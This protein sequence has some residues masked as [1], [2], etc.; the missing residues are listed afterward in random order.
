MPDIAEWEVWSTTARVVVTDPSA[1]QAA[2]AVV[3]QVLAEVDLAA[4]R[5]RPDSEIVRLPLAEGRPQPVGPLLA[6]LVA[7]AL[8]AA[9]DTDGDVDPTLAD[10]LAANGYD[11]DIDL[12]DRVP[13]PAASP[14]TTGVPASAGAGSV[15][16]TVGAQRRPVLG[17]VRR[18]RPDWRRIRLDGGTLTLP[19]GVGLDLGATAKAFAADRAARLVA[20]SCGTGV[21]VGLGGDI[22]TAGPGPE[23]GWRIRVQDGDDEPGCTVALPAGSALATSSTIRRRWVHHG[24]LVHHVLDPRTGLPAE[25]VWRTV[26]VAAPTCLQAN[27]LTTAALVRGLPAR[28]WLRGLGA[29]ARLVSLD[30][31]L[32][33]LNGWP[34]E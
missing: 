20:Q 26:S 24:R 25:P 4:S 2:R 34:T 19:A 3:E 10:S 7:A 8:A 13:P 22:A 12:L 21:L 29:P 27:T 9:R 23:G 5:F 6:E 16:V 14:S 28:S 18:P 31:D 32:V 17:V 33:T 30:G 15:V 11:R 1:L